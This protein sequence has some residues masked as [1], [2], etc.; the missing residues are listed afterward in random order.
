MPG[1]PVTLSSVSER[2]NTTHCPGAGSL[3]SE[4]ALHLPE[5]DRP[6]DNHDEPGR[7]QSE[8][9][10]ARQNSRNELE[11]D[12]A[13]SDESQGSAH[14]GQERPLVGQAGSLDGQ[15]ISELSRLPWRLRA[16]M[17]CDLPFRR[18]H[19]R[20]SSWAWPA[21]GYTRTPGSV[22]GW[23]GRFQRVV[24]QPKDTDYGVTGA[25][26]RSTVPEKNVWVSTGLV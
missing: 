12:H 15:M 4:A 10:A 13:A 16:R 6:D 20:A 25:H 24:I 14:V 23:P 26:I 22:P 3:L 19:L 9:A 11:Q 17:Q 18:P 2:C 7:N 1:T 8:S 21:Q 5:A